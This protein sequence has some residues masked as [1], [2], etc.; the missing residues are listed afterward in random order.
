MNL[1]RTLSLAPLALCSTLAFADSPWL[2]IPGATRLNLSYVTQSADELYAGTSK[3]PLPD[4]LDQDSFALAIEHGLSDRWSVFAKLGYASSDFGPAGDNDEGFSDTRLGLAWRVVDEYERAGWPTLTARA[5]AIIA[6]DYRPGTID[7][8]GDGASGYELALGVGKDLHPRLNVWGS[9]GFRDRES[10]VPSDWFYDLNLG[11]GLSS[12]LAAVVAYEAVR[13]DGG[14]DIGGPGFSPTRFE[15]TQEDRD[16]LKLGL[17]YA[18]LADL[19][20]SLNY[21]QVLDG[22]NTPISDAWGL[23]LGYDF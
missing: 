11:F 12:R 14:T 1:I 21:A 20:L 6:G 5:A 2:P 9:L 18:V 13:A 23:A 17:S 7:A 22:R 8:I 16:L 3:A 15:A 4:D 19:A 10:P